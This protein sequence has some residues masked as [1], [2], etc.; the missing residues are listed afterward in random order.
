MLLAAAA[1]NSAM[2]TEPVPPQPVRSKT[3]A[4]ERKPK[5]VVCCKKKLL[6]DEADLATLRVLMT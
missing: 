3:Q 5:A 2:E 1:R 4:A 6:S